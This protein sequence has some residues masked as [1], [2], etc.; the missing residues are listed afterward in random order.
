LP[1]FIFLSKCTAEVSVSLKSRIKEKENDQ[2][3]IILIA[4]Y[5][6][7]TY[8]QGKAFTEIQGYIGTFF[9]G[10]SHVNMCCAIQKQ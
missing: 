7:Q 10:P 8:F 1:I 5:F 3:F 6:V 4:A 9:G 2:I